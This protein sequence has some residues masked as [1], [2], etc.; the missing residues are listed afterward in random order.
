MGMAK[1]N[2]DPRILFLLQVD[3]E[4]GECWEWK[5]GRVQKNGRG[6]FLLNGKDM[7]VHRASYLLFVGELEFGKH[8]HHL[9]DN[10]KCVR[11]DHLQA[12]SNTDHQKVESVDGGVAQRQRD[13]THCPRGHEYTEENT[14]HSAKGRHCR[15]C[16]RERFYE[17]TGRVRPEGPPTPKGEHWRQKTHCPKGHP[18]EGYNLLLRYDG[19]R[20]CR[21]CK[22]ETARLIYHRKKQQQNKKE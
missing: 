10:R 6:K 13:K 12:L 2:I 7:Y 16:K 11:P 4:S 19:A 3:T 17:E 15:T 21:A 18:Y 20:V 9:C 14:Y 1:T 22:S 5:G 8:V